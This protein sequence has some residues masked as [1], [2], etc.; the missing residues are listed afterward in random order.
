MEIHFFIPHLMVKELPS[1]RK[2]NHC[3]WNLNRLF[4]CLVYENRACFIAGL[5]LIAEKR[6]NDLCKLFTCI[7]FLLW[8]LDTWLNA[9]VKEIL[10]Q[11]IDQLQL[12]GDG[13]ITP[14]LAD[15]LKNYRNRFTYSH[16]KR[17]KNIMEAIESI[18][19][20]PKIRHR[21]EIEHFDR[22]ECLDI[23]IDWDV[24][25]TKLVQ[26]NRTAFYRAIECRNPKAI[27]KLLSKGSFIGNQTNAT[28]DSNICTVAA[29]VI[30]NHFDCCI[31]K[32]IDDDQF[33]EIDLKNFI[34]P[35][36]ESRM[37]D[38]KCSDE[39]QSIYLL[40]NSDD[41]KYLVAHPLVSI[42]VFLKW[43]RLVPILYIDFILYMIF[44][45]S[46]VGYILAV[47][48]NMAKSIKMTMTVLTAILTVY[49][50][51]RKISHLVFDKTS[52]LIQLRDKIINVLQCCHTASIV[53][54]V[55]LLLFH[56]SENDVLPIKLATICILLI[57]LE[58]F[59]L[60][61]SLF[62]SFS[63]YYAMFL[64]IAMSSARCLQ[65]YAIFL[66]AFS[67]SFYLLLRQQ[68]LVSQSYN[69]R[70][71]DQTDYQMFQR[72]N[73]FDHIRS[74]F[75]KTMAMSSTEFDTISSDFDSN[76]FA[77]YLFLGFQFFVLI[78]FMNMLI[79][80]AI[81]DVMNIRSNATETRQ[82]RRIALLAHYERIKSYKNHWIR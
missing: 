77:S 33:L 39:M 24:N 18:M 55:A 38:G 20:E 59:N 23:L 49:I 74:S 32:C 58:L 81:S 29:K 56:V 50:A 19:P 9:S 10:Y 80:L 68:S 65:L 42:F 78:V 73:A 61:G 72:S 63:I 13:V 64:N 36:K 2:R 21:K 76:I 3:L 41:H 48:E 53:V 71:I 47:A 34:P 12:M 52:E 37:C 22:V 25:V 60:A 69:N 17:Y 62:W 1:L 5:K 31:S 44:A 6:P 11:A 40:S 51:A 43:N 8:Q 16:G 35:Q 75:L 15:I 28:D 46:T 54:C 79:G 57:A 70:G 66:P 14:D 4:I 67:L 30:E 27:Y 45:L 82:I 26:N 7:G